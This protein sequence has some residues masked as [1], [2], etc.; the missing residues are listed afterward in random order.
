[1][2]SKQ[3]RFCTTQ[4]N[5]GPRERSAKSAKAL[6][7]RAVQALICA[8]RLAQGREDLKTYSD[9]LLANYPSRKR[10]RDEAYDAMNSWLASGCIPEPALSF[11]QSSFPEVLYFSG[12]AHLPPSASTESG[13]WTQDDAPELSVVGDQVPSE[14]TEGFPDDLQDLTS[15]VWAMVGL[16]T[17]DER[18]VHV[19]ETLIGSD[20]VEFLLEEKFNNNRQVPM[21]FD[22][23]L[24][25][26][27]VDCNLSHRDLTKFLK[28]LKKFKT[29]LT[30]EAIKA[31]PR[32]AK[33]F[34]RLDKSDTATID[35]FICENDKKKVIGEYV[36]YGLEAALVGQSPGN[37]TSFYSL[38]YYDNPLC[39]LYNYCFAAC[40]KI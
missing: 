17:G 35:T 36:H 16:E 30:L 24:R 18:G 27:A 28:L 14:S 1:M 40:L 2:P 7:L 10:Y 32:T 19:L 6:P 38:N 4:R 22:R 3:P 15:R 25:H 20:A 23:L 9:L 26:W 13:N 5:P 34:L 37:C 12:L 8:N 33:T 29:P 39:V 21:T 31:L 11:L